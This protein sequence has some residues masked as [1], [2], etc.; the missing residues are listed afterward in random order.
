MVERSL[1]S[2]TVSRFL[3]AGAPG[4]R[5]S[6]KNYQEGTLTQIDTNHWIGQAAGSG[7]IPWDGSVPPRPKV[8]VLV[9]LGSDP[10][11]VLRY[12]YHLAA[13]TSHTAVRDHANSIISGGY[14]F[15]DKAGNLT[16]H[17]P[18]TV[19][20]VTIENAG[21]S[22]QYPTEASLFVDGEEVPMGHPRGRP[23][24]EEEP[25]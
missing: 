7:R 17:S 11:V 16:H 14:R 9:N 6:T 2:G 13:M 23:T 4:S 18:A 20:S 24:G 21:L 15:V 8:T 25:A 5:S 22:Q 3:T 10:D 1:G 19:R 12:V